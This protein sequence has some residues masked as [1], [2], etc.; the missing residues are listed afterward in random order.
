MKY[1]LLVTC[2]V[3]F[4]LSGLSYG[5]DQSTN[6]RIE[7]EWVV[8]PFGFYT[9]DTNVGFGTGATYAF[10][11]AKEE[12][13][14]AIQAALI[15]TQLKQV[16][17]A[18]NPDIYM[19]HN[20]WHWQNKLG[21][22]FYPDSFYGLGPSSVLEDKERYV[23]RTWEWFSKL[24]YNWWGQL[25]GGLLFDVK[26]A[27]LLEIEDDPILCHMKSCS[28]GKG[29]MWGMGPVITLDSRDNLFYPTGGGLIELGWTAF[30]ADRQQEWYY[31][32]QVDMR[33]FVPLYDGV[34]LGMQGVWFDQQ[35]QVPFV[36]MSRLG[37]YLRG[38]AENRYQDLNVWLAQ[39]ELRLNIYDP[40]KLHLFWGTGNVFSRNGA[41]PGEQFKWAGGFG[42]RYRVS[43]DN[44]NIKFDIAFNRENNTEIYFGAQEMF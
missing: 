14:T 37:E 9:P 32:T 40:F 27:T 38:Y 15:Y 26:H 29:L 30:P 2:L 22:T 10:A 7:P 24:E 3:L 11:R 4:F 36:Q 18:L 6:E 16:K 20:T 34:I 25:Y 33:W 44:L 12:R 39:A 28:G 8:I 31:R 41:E 42:L 43:K 13:P 19:K 1:I 35:G 21:Y 17:I 23:E 5:K